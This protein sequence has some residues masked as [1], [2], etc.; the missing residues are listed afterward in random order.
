MLGT[1]FP[2]EPEPSNITREGPFGEY[3]M[4]I[5]NDRV[6]AAIWRMGPYKA[7]GIDGITAAMLRKAWPILGDDITDL[8]RTCI[9]GGTFPKVWRKASLIIIPK[10]GKKDK[11]NPKPYRPVSILPALGK[12]L[13]TLMIQDLEGE[14]S[15]NDF[16]LQHGFV[17]GRSTITA[18][19]SLY[20]WTEDSKCRHV[21]GAFLDI[22]WAF[23]NVGWAPVMDRIDE[24]GASLRTMSMIKSYLE[25]RVVTLEL[26]DRSYT[27]RL[28]RGCPQ[29]SQLGPTLWKVAMTGLR[30]LELDDTTAMV[31]YADD[32]A[33]MVGVARPQ[34]AFTRI[35]KHLDTLQDWR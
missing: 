29:G 4:T 21:F 7:P 30:K 17:P 6:K 11:D 2:R 27:K 26:E 16:D 31:L 28:E 34:T 20:K 1:F 33:L 9:V 3:T 32:I 19:K 35:E 14:I 23:N 18:I 13:E 24:M 8:F 5:D 25:D 22:T 10:P 15:L 12:A